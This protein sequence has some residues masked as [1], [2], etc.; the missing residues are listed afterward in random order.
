MT[1][2]YRFLT[3]PDT[4][5]F[6]HK[7][8]EALSKGWELYGDPQYASDPQTGMLRCGQAVIKHVDHDYDPGMRLGDQ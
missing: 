4:S 3:G 1:R 8:S 5:E 6:C 7:V 2:L